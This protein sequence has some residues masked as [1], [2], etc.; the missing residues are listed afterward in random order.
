MRR[1]SSWPVAVVTLGLAA[2][3]CGPA[4]PR[5]YGDTSVLAPQVAPV[6]GE[7]TPEH[8]NVSL[9]QPAN[10]TVFLVIP[11][12][13]PILL[14]PKDSTTSEYFEAGAHEVATSLMGKGTALRDSA[15]MQ[16]RARNPSDTRGGQPG[17]RADS[18]IY[19]STFREVGYLFVF[20]SQAPIPY[21]T[22][23]SRVAAYTIPAN[24]AEAISAVTKL[25]RDATGGATPWA[26]YSI[27]YQP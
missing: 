13:T 25:L 17:S 14:F 8:V 9:A 16:R 18:T 7:K 21:S 15:A 22:L 10:A 12:R 2:L 27:E 4:R 24:E 5:L 26:A 11:G 20:A 6:K 23:T 19:Y 3:A 1:F